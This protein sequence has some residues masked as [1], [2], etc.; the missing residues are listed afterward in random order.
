M[1]RKTE[2]SDK[3]SYVTTAELKSVIA[4]FKQTLSEQLT[5]ATN[6]QTTAL[7]ESIEK[8]LS[9]LAGDIDKNIK[10]QVD[11]LR[12]EMEKSVDEKINKEVQCVKQQLC[13]IPKPTTA[14]SNYRKSL[15]G[16]ANYSAGIFI[17]NIHEQVSKIYPDSPILPALKEK[18]ISFCER[19]LIQLMNNYVQSDEFKIEKKDLDKIQFIGKNLTSRGLVLRFTN[20]IF[21]QQVKTR[22][23]SLNKVK[24]QKKENHLMFSPLKTGIMY[25]DKIISAYN[26]LLSS[27][28]KHNLI[29]AFYISLSMEEDKINVTGRARLAGSVKFTTLS[30]TSQNF[31]QMGDELCNYTSNSVDKKKLKMFQDEVKQKVQ[32]GRAPETVP[33]LPP[34][35]DVVVPPLS[36]QAPTSP[37]SQ[38]SS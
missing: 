30:L 18:P 15:D 5:L 32:T 24:K 29:Q 19:E 23:L 35:E 26:T 33:F 10:F 25:A 34:R 37:P 21:C 4:D 14:I 22:I 7:Q 8:K 38:T 16:Y 13:K 17:H 12:E 2:N 28:K 6:Q 11:S 36:I 1:P 20:Q 3:M 9:N 31:I 27:A